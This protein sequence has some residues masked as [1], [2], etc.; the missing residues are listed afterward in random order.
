MTS[1]NEG[2]SNGFTV[3]AKA[4]DVVLTTLTAAQGTVQSG[5]TKT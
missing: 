4:K 3:K 5:L 1:L 2:K